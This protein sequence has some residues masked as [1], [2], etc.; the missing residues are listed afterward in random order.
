M[1]RL[2]FTVLAAIAAMLTSASPALAAGAPK[3][4]PLTGYNGSLAGPRIKTGDGP[5]YFKAIGPEVSRADLTTSGY[6]TFTT[7]VKTNAWAANWSTDGMLEA[8]GFLRVIPGETPTYATPLDT[9]HD[10]DPIMWEQFNSANTG[11]CTNKKF[12]RKG[13]VVFGK[14]AKC[15]TIPGR[16][17]NS[18]DPMPNL[19]ISVTLNG[20]G[21]FRGVITLVSGGSA[22]AKQSFAG[23]MPGESGTEFVPV[24]RLRAGSDTGANLA[25]PGR[26]WKF[27]VVQ[28][29]LTV[30][31]PGTPVTPPVPPHLAPYINTGLGG[32]ARY[33]GHH[34]PR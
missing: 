28:S 27:T 17:A 34:V 21:R 2:F 1:R 8:A 7:T 25:N 30:Y 19:R 29:K 10:G 18:Q 14:G 9:A 16:A 13:K 33:V 6:A 15:G 24:V 11:Y 22:V 12:M 5:P 4:T 20:S 32:M 3:T 26:Q 31:R 23:T